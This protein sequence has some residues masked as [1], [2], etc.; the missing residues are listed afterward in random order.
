MI[1]RTEAQVDTL[2]ALEDLQQAGGLSAK[3]V[4]GC[5]ALILKLQ[6]PVRI[7]LL[8]LPGSGKRDLLSALGDVPPPLAAQDLPTLEL[9]GGDHPLTRAVLSDG[10]R[11]EAPGYP[12]QAILRQQP[13]FLQVTSPA[14]R[15]TGRRLLLVASDPSASD[16]LAGLAWAA[17][18]IDLALWCSRSWSDDEQRIWQAA[19]DSLRNHAFLILTGDTRA[20]PTEG[21]DRVFDLSRTTGGQDPMPALTRHI[22]RVIEDARLEDIHAAQLFLRRYGHAPRPRSTPPAA[23]PIAPATQPIARTPQ[24]T[25]QPSRAR[26][27]DAVR[28]DLTRLFQTVRDSASGLMERGATAPEDL[29]AEFEELFATLAERVSDNDDLNDSCPDLTTQITEAHD[30]ALLLR[31]EGGPEQVADAAHLLVQVRNDIQQELAA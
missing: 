28:G 18:R 5:G 17:N 27:P 23:Q 12:D 21:F 1:A 10:S 26:L 6:A 3:A 14:Q 19:P 13:V 25:A 4:A 7:G 16:M 31:I 24:L 29:L 20:A 30:L 2:A 11:L 22:D 8:G 15:L 9:A